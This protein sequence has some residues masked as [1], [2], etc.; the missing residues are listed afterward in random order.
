MSGRHCSQA[1][2]VEARNVRSN[3]A[4]MPA[5]H[6]TVSPTCCLSAGTGQILSGARL[7][8][9]R[10]QKD[11]RAEG[12]QSLIA[13]AGCAD[14][15]T[16]EPSHWQPVATRARRRVAAPGPAA[17]ARPASH[18]FGTSRPASPSETSSP[19]Y[20]AGNQYRSYQRVGRRPYFGAGELVT[21]VSR[22]APRSD[23]RG[24]QQSWTSTG[25]PKCGS[26]N[27]HASAT[28]RTEQRG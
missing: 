21:T 26:P 28:R 9:R 22:R 1:A 4:S 12:P 6:P 16:C 17:R 10:G 2:G 3:N 15:P 18:V 11:G 7:P 8:R 25:W 13:Q 23:S 27:R 14:V 19:L 5:S 24:R 20:G